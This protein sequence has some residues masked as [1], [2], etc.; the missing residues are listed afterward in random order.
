MSL[1]YISTASLILGISSHCAP[2]GNEIFLVT[3]PDSSVGRALS[4][5]L[6][7]TGNGIWETG[8]EAS[9]PL[10]VSWCRTC[11]LP[12]AVQDFSKGRDSVNFTQQSHI[13]KENLGHTNNK[14]YGI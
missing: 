2:Q 7:S 5:N 14:K 1:V 10:N 9:W 6:T 11:D 3:S 8:L 12:G 4:G 13:K